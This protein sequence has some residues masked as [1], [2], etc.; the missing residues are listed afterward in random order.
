MRRQS[1]RVDE[2]RTDRLLLRR[3][4][5]DDVA[6]MHR[7]MSDP[8]AMRY[9][10]T[11]PHAEIGQ[12]ERWMTSMV[13]ADPATSDDFIVTLGGLLIGK[14]GAWKLPEVGFLLDPAHWG[15]GFALEA[16][17]A[18]I[19]RRRLLG[20]TELTADVD[21][22]NSASIRLL[23]RCGFVETHRA[24]GTWQVGDELCD[25]VYFRLD[26]APGKPF[27]GI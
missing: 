5:L 14:L 7:I 20:S 1:K 22:R 19:D 23:A 10:S 4:R 26:L 21:P 3:A 15:Q 18:F 27:A 9:W 16:M 24:A 6:P 8:V 2:L 12:T 25:S 13:E 11:P 17:I